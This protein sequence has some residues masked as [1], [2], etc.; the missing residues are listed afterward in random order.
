MP[1]LGGIALV[2]VVLVVLFHD[3]IRRNQDKWNALPFP[4]GLG[5]GWTG[6]YTRGGLLFVRGVIVLTGVSTIYA[7]IRLIFE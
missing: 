5:D 1:I 3:R 6:K 2:I 4:L 7:G